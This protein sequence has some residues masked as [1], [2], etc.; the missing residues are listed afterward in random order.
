MHIAANE[1]PAQV[2]TQAIIAISRMAR[3]ALLDSIV[4]PLHRAN[5]P[6]DSTI[7]AVPGVL[8]VAGWING[9]LFSAWIQRRQW[10]DG[11][12]RGGWFGPGKTAAESAGQAR[13]KSFR[14]GPGVAHALEFV[15]DFAL[16]RVIQRR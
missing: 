1:S 2:E 6:R 8:H 13:T 4:R 9:Q 16:G 10:R 5:A 7:T 14:A 12:A 15:E 11:S 3:A